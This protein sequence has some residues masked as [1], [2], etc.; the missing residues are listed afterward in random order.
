MFFG[1]FKLFDMKC[2]LCQSKM[3]FAKKRSIT[4]AYC[5]NKECEKIWMLNKGSNNQILFSE[6]YE[7]SFLI[8]FNVEL[9]FNLGLPTG[10]YSFGKPNQIMIRRDMYYFQKGNELEN[11]Q[12]MQRIYAGQEGAFDDFGIFMDEFEDF[13]YKIK[14]KSVVFKKYSVSGI[15]IRQIQI[16]DILKSDIIK[17][18]IFKTQ[19]QFQ[20]DVNQFLMYYALYFPNNNMVGQFQHDVRPISIYEFNKCLFNCTVIIDG[21]RF[22]VTP[23]IQDFTNLKGIPDITYTNSNNKIDE[24]EK[25]LQ[26]QNEIPILTHQQLFVLARSLFRTNKNYMG[27]TIITTAMTA[28]EALMYSL[29]ENH[30]FFLELKKFR[31]KIFKNNKKLKKPGKN[32]RSF[33]FL[34][35]YTAFAIYSISR[36]IKNFQPDAFKNL[37]EIITHFKNINIAR[38][39]RNRIVHGA[40]FECIVT[41]DY[42]LEKGFTN[43]YKIKYYNFQKGVRSHID[44]NV[45]FD[46]F[47]KIY[48]I[49]EKMLLETLNNKINWNI[50]SE[51]NK[52]IIAIS[53]ESSVES[54]KHI[55]GMISNTNWRETKAY[56]HDLKPPSVPP[57]HYLIGINNMNGRRIVLNNSEEFSKLER[58]N[59]PPITIPGKS[60][61]EEIEK[62]IENKKLSL[63]IFRYGQLFLFCSCNECGFILAIHNHHLL[64]NNHC[65]KCK[66]QFN[67]IDKWSDAV[68]AMFNNEEYQLAIPFIKKILELDS[69]NNVALN[70]LGGSF[71]HL[72][73]Y[74]EA[75]YQFKQ[76]NVEEL[77]NDTKIVVLCHT[78]ICYSEMGENEK[79]KKLNMD[80]LKI[81]PNNEFANHNWCRL[82]IKE[83]NIKDAN[84]ICDKLFELDSES[85]F[86]FFFKAR[87]ES[88]KGNI[89]SALQNLSSAIKHD[90]K[91]KDSAK[92]SSDFDNL[93][94]ILEFKE[95]VG[96]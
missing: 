41:I 48:D 51:Y 30:P 35:F 82:L 87:I 80:A 89:N 26:S 49:L 15:F 12:T 29:E 31:E 20:K 83:R 85:P 92:E 38:I 64:R 79:A 34:E 44:F 11:I 71:L 55:I 22:N 72:K 96:E 39:I 93:R 9:P 57:D 61:S 74:E 37:K 54:A 81:D 28:Y 65:S 69:T 27:A 75:L 73:Q 50:S 95:L 3:N 21:N 19:T 59:N 78:S 24:F 2:P 33:G 17:E 13:T 56:N 32:K 67:L 18:V 6:S 25:I 63:P 36:F 42:N 66:T 76:I 10:F 1:N 4:F 8:E 14:L 46:S 68:F 77:D 7:K 43:N 62:L 47:L 5:T 90:F 84:L 94:N 23:I 86:A 52:E 60:T 40:K 16:E 58:F 45:L 70:N 91:L 53:V 88:I